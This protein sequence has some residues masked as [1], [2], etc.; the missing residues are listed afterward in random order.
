[1]SMKTLEQAIL[2]GARV[3][4]HNPKLRFKDIM[5]WS[6]GDI[7]VRENEVVVNVPYPGVF[8]AVNEDCDKRPEA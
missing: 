6:T 5:E 2:V 4:L 7:E 3:V 1:M 8:V